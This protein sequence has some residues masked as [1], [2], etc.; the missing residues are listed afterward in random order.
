MASQSPVVAVVLLNWNGKDFLEKFLP[1]L[2]AS[3]SPDTLIY[4]AD[5]ASSDD[6]VDFVKARFPRV[7]IIQNQENLGFAEGYN[8]ALRQINADYYVLLNQDV[9]VTSGWIDPVIDMMEANPIVAACQPKILSFY[10]KDHFEYAGASGG[11]IDRYGYPFCRGRIFDTLEQD[12]GQ[13]DKP[14]QVFWATGAALFVRA[15][16]YHRAGGLDPYFFAHMEEID[17]CWRLQRMGYEVWCCPQST[18]YHVGG[19]SLAQGSPKKMFLNFRN[20]LIMMHKNMRGWERFS[21]IFIRFVLD[22]VA[23]MQGL[24]NGSVMELKAVL[25]AHF[26][27][28]YW[29]FGGA[30]RRSEKMQPAK[31][32]PFKSMSTVYLPSIAWQYFVRKKKRFSSLEWREKKTS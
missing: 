15:E 17:L 31:K 24:V 19:G 20:N 13:Y 14:L 8:R 2:C 25:K 27:F 5:N 23:A 32:K 9:E 16:L 3:T 28:Y 12:R 11:F 26:A 7:Q 6:S 18:V 1:T 10:Q 22:G 21:T 4:L 30:A 29:L